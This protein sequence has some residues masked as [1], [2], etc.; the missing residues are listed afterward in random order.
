MK[1]SVAIGAAILVMGIFAAVTEFSILRRPVH[2]AG[3]NAE[4][5][6]LI[7][8]GGHIL[9]GTGNPWFSADIGIRGDHIAAIGK[10]DGATTTRVIDANGYVVA[11]GFIDMLGQSESSLLIDNRSLSKISQGIT[12]EITGEGQS[13]APQDTLTLTPMKPFLDEFHL[14]VDWTDL[15]GYFTRLEKSGTPLNLGTYVGAAQVREAVIGDGDRPPTADELEKMKGLVAQAMQQ[16]AMGISTALIY[17]PGH[18]AKTGELIALASVAGK[19]GGIYATHMRS[20]GQTEMEALDEAIRI[21]REGH[22]PVEVFHLKVSGKSRWGSMP[23]VVGRI[24]TARDSGLDIAA[25]MYPYLAGATALASCLPPWVADGGVDK[26]LARLRDPEVRKRIE[27]E[28]AADHPG[29][30]NLYFDSGGPSGVM[31]SGVV[32]P[33]LKKYDGKTVAQ[34]A[35]AEKKDPLDAMFD[36]ILADGAQTGA[37][38][39]ISNEQDLQYGLKQR[40]TSIGL[41]ANETALD[42]PLYEPHNHPRAWGSMP[43]FLGHYVRNLHLMPLPEAIRK[44]T[45]MPAQEEHLTGR[46]LL[47]PGFFADVTIFDPA[48]IIDKATYTDPNQESAGVEYVIVNGKLEFAD[49]KLT[50]VTA[51]RPLRG[52]GWH[53]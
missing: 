2:A 39:F 43:R 33:D 46:G 19:Y 31:I 12:S 18:Y 4:T 1:R 35:E 36:F 13:I 8:R 42:G 48:T 17:P 10:L 9:D 29:W 41:D 26:L 3:Q 38:Y 22:L 14:T 11:P 30:E 32:N 28:M 15:A 16:G 51:G 50:G 44:I 53:E 37:L 27:A 23:K 5:Y 24:Q 49:G 40:W 34:M 20:E 25:N 6:D 47:K 21:G 7:I 52:P 45:S